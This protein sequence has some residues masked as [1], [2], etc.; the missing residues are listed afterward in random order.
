MRKFSDP[1]YGRE[2]LKDIGARY[3]K[4]LDKGLR[5]KVNRAYAENSIVGMRDNSYFHEDPRIMEFDGVKI[6]MEIG[7]HE[8]HHFTIEEGYDKSVNPNLT[9]DYGW[10]IFCNDRAILMY[11]RTPKTGWTKTFHNEFYGMVGRVNFVSQDPALLPWNTLKTDVDTNNKVFIEALSHMATLS[12][13]WRQFASGGIKKL[14][15]SG[16]NLSTLPKRGDKDP[17]IAKSKQPK[18]SPAQPKQTKKEKKKT[19]PTKQ[20]KKNH[21]EFSE[22]LPLDLN[23]HF[24]KDKLLCLVHEAKRHCLIKKPYSGMALIRMLFEVASV[25]FCIR[26]NIID[27]MKQHVI[28]QRQ[29]EKDKPLSKKEKLKLRPKLHEI[30][31][32]MIDNQDLWAP[33]KSGYLSNSL[34][35]M[36][37]ARTT[38][39]TAIHDPYATISYAQVLQVKTAVLPILRHLLE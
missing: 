34:A 19:P 36:Q 33:D 25:Q 10:T 12:K 13:K 9:Q 27:N 4:F 7:Q 11:D 3:G 5:L 23:E 2:I 14:R 28:D 24:C 30:V 15:N 1:D 26:K 31:A 37:G 38:L 20:T 32:F 29:L 35:A 39:N 17:I 16:V 8:K 6:Y 22:I 18:T 21:N